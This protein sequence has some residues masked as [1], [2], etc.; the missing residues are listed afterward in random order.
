MQNFQEFSADTV[1]DAGYANNA[2]DQITENVANLMQSEEGNNQG[3][4]Q[5]LQNLSSAVA[6]NQHSLSMMSEQ[7][8]NLNEQI[9][10]LNAANQAS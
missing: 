7:F 5:F 9:H 4:Q 6:L 10:S 1:A 2:I 3:A 8:N